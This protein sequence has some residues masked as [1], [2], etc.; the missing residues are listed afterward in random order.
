[1]FMDVFCSHAPHDHSAP[2]FNQLEGVYFLHFTW[3]IQKTQR[4]WCVRGGHVMTCSDHE[5]V[6]SQQGVSIWGWC[7]GSVL[8]GVL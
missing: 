1:M 7:C 3:L 2:Q 8:S 5:C 6:T 4:V